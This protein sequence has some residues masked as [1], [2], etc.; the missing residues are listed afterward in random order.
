[1]VAVSKKGSVTQKLS[2]SE[3]HKEL[4]IAQR[5]LLELIMALP[6]CVEVEGFGPVFDEDCAPDLLFSLSCWSDV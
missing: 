4:K 2:I 1:L 3:V 6:N 5:K